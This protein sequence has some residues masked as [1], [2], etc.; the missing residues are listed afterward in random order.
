MKER[1]WRKKRGR[2][3]I[4]NGVYEKIRTLRSKKKKTK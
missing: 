4:K 3:A 2:G 1:A